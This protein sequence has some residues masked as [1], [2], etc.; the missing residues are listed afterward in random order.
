MPQGD[1]ML[2]VYS[3][4]IE[5]SA[6]YTRTHT[7]PNICERWIVSDFDVL[8]AK[9]NYLLRM[10][11]CVLLFVARMPGTCNTYLYNVKNEKLS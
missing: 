8:R 2:H 3:Y 5:L 4:L 1:F 7:H 6:A 9:S 10:K 11:Q